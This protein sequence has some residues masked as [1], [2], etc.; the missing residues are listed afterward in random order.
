MTS[1]DLQRIADAAIACD[2]GADHDNYGI[3]SQRLR[4]GIAQWQAW[5]EK[6]GRG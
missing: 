6:A 5:R 3:Q 4:D 1:D 2:I